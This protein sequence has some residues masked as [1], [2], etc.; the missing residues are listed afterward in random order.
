M[1]TIFQDAEGCI[2]IQFLVQAKAMNAACYLQTL[3]ELH[4]A[5][6]TDVQGRKGS[7]FNT[8]HNLILHLC[9]ERIQMN[10]WKLLSHPP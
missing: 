9:K 5:F 7:S 8:P 3:L 6:M 10:G 1:R 4:C 2:L